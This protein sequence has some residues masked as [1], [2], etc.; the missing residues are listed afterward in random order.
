MHGENVR[1]CRRARRGEDPHVRH[2]EDDGGVR[3]REARGE[4][5]Q[6]QGVLLRAPGGCQGQS[7]GRAHP[8]Q[9]GGRGHLPAQDVWDIKGGKQKAKVQPVKSGASIG[10]GKGSKKA[11]KIRRLKGQDLETTEVIANKSKKRRKN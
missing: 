7:G 10:S 4:G 11:D 6:Q 8:L 9:Q 3:V 2:P 1:V 5:S